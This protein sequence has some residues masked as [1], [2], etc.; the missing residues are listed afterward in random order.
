VLGVSDARSAE[1]VAEYPLGTYPS[2]PAAFSALVGDANFACTALQLDQWVS[3]R[4]R[5]YAYEF[6]DDGAP[7]RYAPPGAVA[8]IATHSSELQ[9]LFSLP[10]APVPGAL[11]SDQ[12]SLAAGMRTAWARFAANG[13]PS[14]MAVPWPAF[15]AAGPNVVSLVTPQPQVETDF[16]STHHCPFWTAE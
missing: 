9:Y 8:P 7:Q 3:Q 11:D 1:I 2:P 12:E 14:T 6:D 16:A 13:D 4:T 5:T 15:G 10:N